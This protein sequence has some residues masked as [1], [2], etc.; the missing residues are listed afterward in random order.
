MIMERSSLHMYSRFPRFVRAASVTLLL[1]LMLSP[2]SHAYLFRDLSGTIDISGVQSETDD[3]TT[4]TLRQQ[5]TASWSRRMMPNLTVRG[6]LRY[7]KFDLDQAQSSSVW[8]EEWQPSGDL[9]WN[10]PLF[11]L[12]ANAQ[13][14]LSTSNNAAA[15]LTSDNWSVAF[16]TKSFK[17]PK[18][19]LR[20]DWD[21]IY[22]D[23]EAGD[24]DT[25]DRMFV[26]GVDYNVK[27]HALTY[28]FSTRN[29]DNV[30]SN[31]ESSQSQHLLRWNNMAFLGAEKR[32]RVNTNYSF[33]YRSQTDKRPLTGS[34]LQLV[35]ILAALYAHDANADFGNLD[36]VTALT[37][38]NTSAAT[39]P[40][41]DIGNALTDQNIGAD[42]GF[43]RSVG[44][45][46]VYTDRA[47]SDLVGWRVYISGDNLNWE[48]Y[49]AAPTV[50]FNAGFNRYEINFAQVETRYIKVV[51]TGFNDIQTVF[52]T[53]LQLLQEIE[54]TNET[55]ST[56]SQASHLADISA[57]YRHSEKVT[58]SADFSYQH[59]PSLSTGSSRDNFY[60]SLSTRWDQSRI[61]THVLKW[62][63]GFQQFDIDEHDLRNNSALYNLLVAPLD[64]LEFSMS[65][66][67]R[68]SYIGDLKDQDNKGVLLVASGTPLIGL[69]MSSEIGYSR[70]D[71]IL[72]NS[73][74]DIWR[75]RFS[76]DGAVTRTLDA[77][78]SFSHQ[79]TKTQQTGRERTRN[80]YS[81]SFN[82]RFTRTIF[83]RGAVD[84]V[85]D[86]NTYISQ[87]YTVSWNMTPRLSV[88]SQANLTS[89]DGD[90]NTQRYSVNANYKLGARSSLYITY[91]SSDF[92]EAGGNKTTSAQAGFRTGF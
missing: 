78:F 57:S 5:Y 75:F 8:Q 59:E 85:D 40:N 27:S 25:R 54:S 7:F 62:Q 33:S 2:L 39:Q 63:Q 13:R 91:S 22:S 77:I 44:A 4:E 28:N 74:S 26:A 37:D 88:S 58:S 9:A 31:L 61:V 34:A 66:N 47:S 32:L 16:H 67:L 42:L 15:D 76:M 51:N 49:T 80:Q 14:R 56:R 50:E 6:S 55:E 11:M 23:N 84:I 70:S 30:I 48:L 81:A 65:A 90:E 17:H 18:V 43:A 46:Y 73:T 41:I 24:R 20:Y 89:D 10:H 53:E 82:Y 45:V 92:T 21:H 29:N 86:E 1:L 87:N 72:A 35:P 52:V 38:G 12:S 64:R 69:N 79:F 3:V 36:S 60:Y 19:T 68:T 83:L 71:Q